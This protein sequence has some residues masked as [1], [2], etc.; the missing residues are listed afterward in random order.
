MLIRCISDKA[1]LLRDWGFMSYKFKLGVKSR[2][3]HM[4]CCS[5]L[6]IFRWNYGCCWHVMSNGGSAFRKML[7]LKINLKM[8]P[9]IQNIQTRKNRRILQ[10]FIK[11]LL[12]ESERPFQF[13]RWFKASL[14]RR[15]MNKNTVETGRHTFKLD[16][17]WLLNCSVA[18][19][20]TTNY[21]VATYNLIKMLP[22]STICC[23]LEQLCTPHHRF[24]NSNSG[25]I[26][27]KSSELKVMNIYIHF[28]N[29][30]QGCYC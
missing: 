23:R 26:I 30:R 8:Y 10:K 27:M 3:T 17:K 15:L 6:Q 2:P 24:S 7:W 5:V 12:E 16:F 19:A 21:L 25:M 9:S 4:R 11:D 18:Y 22:L 20:C 29:I 1:W 13:K 14:T 28:S